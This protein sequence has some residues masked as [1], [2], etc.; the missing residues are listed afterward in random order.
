MDTPSQDGVAKRKNGH[1]LEVT[2]ALLFHMKVPKHFW[3]DAVSTV[4]F[5]INRMLF[6]VFNGDIPYTALFPIKSLF[7]VEPR[8]FGCTYFVRDVCPQV[9]K[10]DL[11]SLK[12]V[13]LGYSQLQK[14]YY[15][16]SPTLNRYLVSADV[17]IFL[18]HSIFSSII[19]V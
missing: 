2:R 8:I 9:T 19:C 13:F 1:L 10:L 16:F 17:I 15:C 3:A 6:F 4:C 11:K 12:C 5:L 14:R 7:P 18:V